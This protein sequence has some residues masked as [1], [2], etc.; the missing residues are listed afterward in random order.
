MKRSS[1]VVVKVKPAV[2][3][4]KVMKSVLLLKEDRGKGMMNEHSCLEMAYA[5]LRSDAAVVCRS[6]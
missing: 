2:S 4:E 6:P 5:L 1:L 3:C